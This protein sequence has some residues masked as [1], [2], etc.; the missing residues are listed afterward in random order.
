MLDRNETGAR[1]L[2]KILEFQEELLVFDNISQDDAEKLGKILTDLAQDAPAPIS[3]R[4]FLGDKIAYEYTMDGDFETRFGWTYR[5]YQLIK[6]TGHSSMHGK[7]R[8][9]FLGELEDL[10]SQPEIYGFGCGGFPIFVGKKE[11]IGAVALS[12]LPDP[13]DH[14]YV[15]RALEKMLGVVTPQIPAEIDEKWIN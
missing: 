10:T 15:V 5:K 12:G 9:M 11:I 3:I 8:A 6:K 2:L 7:V 13:A 14:F 1:E 4:V